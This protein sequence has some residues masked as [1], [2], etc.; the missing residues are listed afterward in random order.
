MCYSPF[1]M[2]TNIEFVVTRNRLRTSVPFYR[3]DL[4]RQSFSATAEA[5]GRRRIAGFLFAVTPVTTLMGSARVLCVRRQFVP[6]SQPIFLPPSFCSFPSR[7]SRLRVRKIFPFRPSEIR[8]SAFPLIPCPSFRVTTD[9]P[10]I[11]FFAF[12][13]PFAFPNRSETCAKR[14]TSMKNDTCSMLNAQ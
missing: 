9:F 2:T 1:V 7:S 13:A 14:P 5:F 4:S 3:A 6:L 10:S 12:F 11:L 8:K